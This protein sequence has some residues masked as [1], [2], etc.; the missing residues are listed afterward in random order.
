MIT[1]IP[2]I[3]QDMSLWTKSEGIV[4]AERQDILEMKN[5]E[6]KSELITWYTTLHDKLT[7]DYFIVSFISYK[8]MLPTDSTS[9]LVMHGT[10]HNFLFVLC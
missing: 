1:I 9:E 7:Q 5:Y 3:L 6:F 8:S 4:L 10:D 2:Q